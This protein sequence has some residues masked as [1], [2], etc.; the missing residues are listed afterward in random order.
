MK[1]KIKQQLKTR[2]KARIRSKV[3]GTMLCPRLSVFRSLKHIRVQLI[4]DVKG[5]SIVSAED[6]ELGATKKNKTELALEVGK[7][8]AKK[9]IKK[10]IDKVVFDRGGN[11][12][13]GRVRAV[14]Q[15]AREGGLKF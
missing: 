14:A 7:I 2:R 6:K 13:I 9:A 4:D 12:Y 10:K 3:K 8:I 11:K 15:G 5:V 1:G